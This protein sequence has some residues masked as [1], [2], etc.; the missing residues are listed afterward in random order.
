M[1]H[2]PYYSALFGQQGATA[3]DQGYQGSRYSEIKKAL[4]VV[5]EPYPEIWGAEGNNPLPVYKAT[6][7]H[8]FRGFLPGGKPDQLLAAATRTVDTRGDLRWGE[9]RNGFRRIVHPN[10]ICLFGMWEIDQDNPYSGYF[11]NGSRGLIISR[12]STNDGA[13]R[14]KKKSFSLVGKVFPTTDENHAD[15]LKPANFFTQ[16]DLG[17]ESTRYINDA[18]MRN[19]PNVTALR[20]FLVGTLI[21]ARLGRVFG[22]VDKEADIRQVHEVAELGKPEGD[23]TNAP[24]FMQLQMSPGQPRVEG[25][26]L[27]FRDEIY[28][29]IFDRGD[30][31]PKRTLSFDILVANEGRTKR[32]TSAY[33]RLTV[34]Q[35]ETIGRIT[36][37]TAVA[38][39]NG[40]HVLHFPHPQWR[41]DRNDPAS[42]V[43]VGGKRVV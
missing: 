36:F 28:S 29:M 32:F 1:S 40:D 7:G 14:G 42:F 17:N 37:N 9:D 3:E 2:C 15:L 41:N 24:E 25:E 34:D 8:A 22:K 35:W 23:A 38:S 21:L 10:G 4:F 12:F 20:R 6:F 27:D 30:P 39:Y 33:K 16:Q 19:S 13:L 11:K 18:K 31:T 43:R 5:R 26:K